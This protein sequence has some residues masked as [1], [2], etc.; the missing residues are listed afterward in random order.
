[1]QTLALRGRH[2][3]VHQHRPYVTNTKETLRDTRSKA[4]QQMSMHHE[5]TC[6]DERAVVL[7]FNVNL[8]NLRKRAHAL[9]NMKKNIIFCHGCHGLFPRRSFFRSRNLISLENPPVLTKPNRIAFEN[10]RQ[11][12][13]QEIR[14]CPQKETNQGGWGW[15]P[16]SFLSTRP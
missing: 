2:H 13:S 5:Q 16:R 10:A 6:L 8:A 1:M 15:R 9:H 11:V 7:Y 3:D 4:H 14:C 12:L